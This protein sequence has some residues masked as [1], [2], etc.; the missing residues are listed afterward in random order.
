MTIGDHAVVGAGAVVTRDVPAFSMAAGSPAIV[1]RTWH[2]DG[3]LKLPK[4][5][6]ESRAEEA[7][8]VEH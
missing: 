1:K 4:A 8:C 6:K 2:D 5:A 3:A 7:E